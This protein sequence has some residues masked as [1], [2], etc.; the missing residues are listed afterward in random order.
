MVIVSLKYASTIYN[1]TKQQCYSNVQL[2]YVLR[3]RRG[4]GS[5]VAASQLKKEKLVLSEDGV[6]GC[7]MR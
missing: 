4:G 1:T 3:T 7:T 5:R 6:G 2:L